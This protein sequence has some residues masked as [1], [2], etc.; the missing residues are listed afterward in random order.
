[1]VSLPRPDV[2]RHRA[3]HS[4]VE[5]FLSGRRP[6]PGRTFASHPLA[7]LE[8]PADVVGYSRLVEADEAGTVSKLRA[9][10]EEVFETLITS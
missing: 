3:R 9:L 4:A 7:H 1:M 10:R 6:V 8:D 2:D 5:T